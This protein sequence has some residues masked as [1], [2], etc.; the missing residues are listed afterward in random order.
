MLVHPM[1]HT[2]KWKRIDMDRWYCKKEIGDKLPIS[3]YSEV[4][5]VMYSSMWNRLIIRLSISPRLG[6]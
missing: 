2:L 4:L 1:H 3:M 6:G 5:S